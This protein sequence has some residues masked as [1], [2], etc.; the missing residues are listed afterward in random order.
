MQ[1]SLQPQRASAF[2]CGAVCGVKSGGNMG[3][4]TI[5]ASCH[6]LVNLSCVP[7]G[8]CQ[9]RLHMMRQRVRSRWF[10]NSSIDVKVGCEEGACQMTSEGKAYGEWWYVSHLGYFMV[11]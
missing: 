6:A 10:H 5:N 8:S 11:D 4:S 2:N 9:P 7:V 3:T 1:S